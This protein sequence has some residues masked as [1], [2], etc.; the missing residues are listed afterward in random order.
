MK[1][2]NDVLLADISNAMTFKLGILC[3]CDAR[4]AVARLLVD[5][6]EGS[7]TPWEVTEF[8][9]YI[10]PTDKWDGYTVEISQSETLNWMIDVFFD[11]PVEKI[12]A[13]HAE[14]DCD[15]MTTIIHRVLDEL[16][17]DNERHVRS[18]V[19]AI[20]SYMS[21]RSETG[22]DVVEWNDF[23]ANTGDGDTI[24]CNLEELARYHYAD[25]VEELVRAMFFGDLRDWDD[26]VYINGYGNI[27]SIADLGDHISY[28]ALAEWLYS[29]GRVAIKV[30][31]YVEH[32]DE[33]W[34]VEFTDTD[35]SLDVIT[36]KVTEELSHEIEMGYVKND[37]RTWRISLTVE[38]IK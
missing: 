37:P 2:Y 7:S 23:V 17:L 5:S 18:I 10:F 21:Y 11:T 32:G 4:R 20:E 6:I 8:C 31:V 29:Q 22:I 19:R 12:L 30:E 9:G 13:G 38:E 3:D 25:N 1:N 35:V 27:C 15:A 34:D 16:L 28:D 33:S 14:V 24:Y 36:D 26:Y